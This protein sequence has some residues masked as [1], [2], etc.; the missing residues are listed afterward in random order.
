[1]K[2]TNCFVGAACGHLALACF[3]CAHVQH[4]ERAVDDDAREVTA[5]AIALP[6]IATQITES[7]TISD[8]MALPLVDHVFDVTVTVPADLQV[9]SAAVVL[10]MTAESGSHAD[11]DLEREHVVAPNTLTRV[12][13]RLPAGVSVNVAVTS[14]TAADGRKLVTSPHSDLVFPA[15]NIE[16]RFPNEGTPRAVQLGVVRGG[17]YTIVFAPTPTVLYPKSAYRDEDGMAPGLPTFALLH[18]A[19]HRYGAGLGRFQYPEDPNSP[20]EFPYRRMECGGD[21]DCT[22]SILSTS[23]RPSFFYVGIN[24]LYTGQYQRI[25]CLPCPVTEPGCTFLGRFDV[26]LEPTVATLNCPLHFSLASRLTDPERLGAPLEL[27]LVRVTDRKVFTTAT[28]FPLNRSPV[29]SEGRMPLGTFI[30]LPGGFS[31]RPFYLNLIQAM[32]NGLD[33]TT[34][35]LPSITVTADTPTIERTYNLDELYAAAKTV[36]QQASR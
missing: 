7:S 2:A 3:A 35:G 21:S 4:H 26:Q 5:A 16:S 27:S 25:D 13:R 36:P 15:E 31:P 19:N 34:Y 29:L 18:P 9:Q 28:G 11:R 14:L 6:P 22:F 23:Q 30:V 12:K 20:T 17:T 10:R 24:A 1:M 33:L 8:V 32:E